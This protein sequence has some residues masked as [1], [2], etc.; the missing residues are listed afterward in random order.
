MAEEPQ[1]TANYKRTTRQSHAST[2]N[3]KRT[4]TSNERTATSN[5]K[6]PKESR[7]W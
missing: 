3:Y 5:Y 1:T 6:E 2:T 4:T 7:S